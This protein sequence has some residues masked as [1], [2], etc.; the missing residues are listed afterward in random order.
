MLPAEIAQHLN[1]T[2]DALRARIRRITQAG[3]VQPWKYSSTD[4]VPDDICAVLIGETPQ[5]PRQAP[6]VDKPAQ[7]PAVAPIEPPRRAPAAKTA[8]FWVLGIIPLGLSLVSWFGVVEL[9]GIFVKPYGVACTLAALFEA[10]MFTGAVAVWRGG[11][12]DQNTL[13]MGRTF[14]VLLCMQAFFNSV[15]AYRHSAETDLSEYFYGLTES[16]FLHVVTAL[17]IAAAI[18]WIHYA[19]IKA[20]IQSQS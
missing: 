18:A 17:L 19:Y 20:A 4:Q 15:A 2:P 14:K 8:L 10:A 1:V 9:I 16:N 12:S 6:R 13:Q 5:K 11:M 7:V 3:T